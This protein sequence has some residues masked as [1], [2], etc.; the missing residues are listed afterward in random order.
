MNVQYW[1]L[2][3]GSP[4]NDLMPSGV[5]SAEGLSAIT[6]PLDPDTE[7]GMEYVILR[8]WESTAYIQYQDFQQPYYS[9]LDIAGTRPNDAAS[10]GEPSEKG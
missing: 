10:H 5:S 8:R 9:T 4:S 2:Q 3:L 6:T 7:I 1:D